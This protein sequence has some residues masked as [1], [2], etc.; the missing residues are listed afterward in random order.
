M[1][2][3]A[4]ARLA[5]ILARVLESQ[6]ATHD[7]RVTRLGNFLRRSSLDALPQLFKVLMGE[8]SIVGPRPAV[9]TGAARYGQQPHGG[10]R[11]ADHTP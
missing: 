9:E 5:E 6:K 4:E 8:M 2:V 11:H 10:A 3:G 7:P 1:V